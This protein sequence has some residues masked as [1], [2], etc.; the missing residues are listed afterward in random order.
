MLEDQDIEGLFDDDEN[1]VELREANIVDLLDKLTFD[2]RMGIVV[3][4]L[5]SGEICLLFAQRGV[6]KTFFL[7]VVS[8]FNLSW[9]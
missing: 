3:P 1:K 6:G 2:P 9:L 7:Y 8:R 5:A 4:W